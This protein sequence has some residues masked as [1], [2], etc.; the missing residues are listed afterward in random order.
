MF[1]FVTGEKL[2]SIADITITTHPIKKFH[3]HFDT[4]VK[5][6]CLLEGS[7]S[8]IISVSE[9]NIIELQKHRIIFVYSHLLES[10][11]KLIYPK[12]N[13]HFI[14]ISHN[15][16]NSITNQYIKYLNE[17]K[18]I[19][20]YG[21]NLEII[22]P[23][24]KV[25]PIGIGNSQ[26]K[27]GNL[28][29]LRSA[30]KQDCNIMITINNILNPNNITTYPK[31]YKKLIYLNFKIKT[32]KA[33]RTPIYDLMKTKSFVTINSNL[34]YS[35]Y[36][37]EL[38]THKFCIVPPGNGID[39]HRTWE[40]LYLGVIPVLKDCIANRH[41]DKLPILLIDDWNDITEEYLDREYQ[42]I[43]MKEYP[44]DYL[45]FSYWKRTISEGH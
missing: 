38:S 1:D 41:F 20:W 14:L 33:V 32:N 45:D 37:Q 2:Q 10:F 11:F 28:D 15:S 3:K 39:C 36:L 44:L 16:D 12:L 26:W 19:K 23:K 40:C 17:D 9:Q 6:V 25:L 30:I 24:L 42:K 18:I 22:H 31:T 13:H 29:I 34:S 27:H 5:K 7:I 8:E 43:W 4:Y 21:Q 35:N